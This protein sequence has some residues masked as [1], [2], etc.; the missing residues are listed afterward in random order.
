MPLRTNFDAYN[1]QYSD[2][3]IAVTMP[4]V[5]LA[6]GPGGPGTTCTQALFNAGQCLGTQNSTVTLNGKSAR[7]YGAEWDITA[8]PIS[9][10]TVEWTGSYLDA[11]AH[12]GRWL[13]RNRTIAGGMSS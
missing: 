2:I 13:V 11:R 8:I 6:T 3:Q 1:T 12:G 4:N 10:L 9:G 7:V 5:V